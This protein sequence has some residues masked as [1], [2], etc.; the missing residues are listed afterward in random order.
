MSQAIGTERVSRVTG[1]IVTKGNFSNNTPNLPQRIA[2]LAEANFANQSTLDTTPKE[3]TSLKQAGDLYGYGSPIYHA[4]RILRPISGSGIGGVPLYVYPQAQASGATAKI[5]EIVPSGTA[6]GN[7]THTLKI[8]GRKVIDGQ[9]YDF[10][11]VSGDTVAQINAKIVECVNKV[12]GSPVDAVNF[13][14][15]VD[16]TSKWKGLTANDIAVSIDDNDSETGVTYTITS[17]QNG[18]GTPSIATALTDF[19]NT[20]NT[21]VINGYGLQS[22]IMASL[23][24]NNGIPATD[25]PTG[26]WSGDIMKPYIAFTGS[27]ADNPSTTTDSYKEDVTIAVC[28][29]PLSEG[30]HIEA[31]ANYA[32]LYVNYAQNNPNLDISGK[33]LPDMPTP[34]SIGSMSDYNNRDSY[35]QKGCSTVDLVSGKYKV[36]DFVTT[37][38]P[39]GELPPQFRYVRNITIDLNIKFG[40]YLL[41]QINVVDHSIAND[42]D[43]VSAASVIKP[44]QWKGIVSKFADNLAERG[45]IA[46]AEFM[47]ESIT[48]DISTTN[49]DRIETFF[50]YKRSG[51]VRIASTVAEAGFNFG[52]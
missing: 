43:I 14:Y 21:V 1:Y 12:L 45:L 7:G 41:E 40:Y 48:V 13:G 8:S 24:A 34:T 51:Y 19:G 2:L 9:S 49:P 17:R 50:R 27:T 20:W 52:N 47:K 32:L 23:M 29:A 16:L 18:S 4:V 42:E 33:F 26:R 25:N 44:K 6:T 11:I 46:D 5:W 22:T 39:D 3:I 37:Y 15:E 31:A 38:H 10:N 30:L 28:P 36:M 35:V